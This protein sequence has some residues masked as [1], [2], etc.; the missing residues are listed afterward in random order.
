MMDNQN[1]TAAADK[2][3]LASPPASGG[4]PVTKQFQIMGLFPHEILYGG[5]LL[6]YVFSQSGQKRT[7]PFEILYFGLVVGAI[8]VLCL[9]CIEQWR[10]LESKWFLLSLA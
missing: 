1:S 4:G 6:V 7:L 9:R 8:P 10:Q 5:L 2:P 3:D